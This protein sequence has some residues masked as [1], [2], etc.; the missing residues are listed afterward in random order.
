MLKKLGLILMGFL[1]LNSIG[2]C[3]YEIYQNNGQYYDLSV[4]SN[5]AVSVSTSTYTTFPAITYGVSRRFK[6]LGEPSAVLYFQL[7]GSTSTITSAGMDLEPHTYYVEN[8][9]F[10]DILMQSTGTAVNVRAQY[11]KRQS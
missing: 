10:G 9:Y 7:G 5:T 3:A 6:I 11:L 2:F 1:A 8:D 4:A